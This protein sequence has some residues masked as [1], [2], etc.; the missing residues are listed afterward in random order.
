MGRT[1]WS[2]APAFDPAVARDSAFASVLIFLILEREPPTYYSAARRL[3]VELSCCS[4][5][6]SAALASIGRLQKIE[7]VN[8]LGQT[9]NHHCIMSR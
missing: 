3:P 4:M 9:G 2:T 5:N 6:C 7:S 1:C 8:P